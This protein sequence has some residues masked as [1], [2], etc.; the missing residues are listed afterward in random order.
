MA[1]SWGDGSLSDDKVRDIGTPTSRLTSTTAAY[2]K[3]SGMV[4]QS[5]IPVRV[6]PTGA[7]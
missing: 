7:G 2:D 5:A 6:E 1:H 4:V 3:V